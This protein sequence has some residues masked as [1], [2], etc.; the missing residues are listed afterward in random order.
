[1]YEQS[2]AEEGSGE[3][4]GEEKIVDADFEEVKDDDTDEKKS[5]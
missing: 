3:A 4:E 1:M 2:Q 5:A